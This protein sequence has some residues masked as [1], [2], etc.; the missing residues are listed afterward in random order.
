M[1]TTSQTGLRSIRCSWRLKTSHVSRANFISAL[2]Q[3]AA[4]LGQEDVVEAGP[5]QLDRAERDP[6]VVE[7]AQDVRDRD[8]AL[9]DV[10]PQPLGHELDRAD[11]ALGPEALLGLVAHR[12]AR[13]E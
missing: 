1:P 2:P 12:A 4:G 3:G 10:E 5:V 13:L 7:H 8:G 11:V 9:V 6:L